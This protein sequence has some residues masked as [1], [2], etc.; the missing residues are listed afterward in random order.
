MVFGWGKKKPLAKSPAEALENFAKK[1]NLTPKETAK[2][3]YE[4]KMGTLLEYFVENNAQIEYGPVNIRNP[5]KDPLVSEEEERY[6][7]IKFL[8]LGAVPFNDKKKAKLDDEIKGWQ[9]TRRSLS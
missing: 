3:F 2:R 9:D 4:M 7:V 1:H 6:Q 8:E 5:M